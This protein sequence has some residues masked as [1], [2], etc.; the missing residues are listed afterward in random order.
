MIALDTN[1]LVRFLVR[2]DPAQARKAKALVDRLT[3][4]EERAY[5]SDIVLCELVWILTRSYRFDRTQVAAAV[6]GLA[7]AKQLRFDSVD[8]VLRA[9][10][11]FE[12]GK[13]DFADYL[14]REH[15]RA[16]ECEKVVTFDE[17]LLEDEL[18]ASP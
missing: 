17:K 12:H 5:V 14:V 2:D 6:D 4:R 18:F 13:G 1:V 16:A 7:R 11:A 15:A 9:L 10:S 8:N 3:E